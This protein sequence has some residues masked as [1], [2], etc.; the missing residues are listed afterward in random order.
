MSPLVIQKSEAEIS[1][2][3]SYLRELLACCETPASVIEADWLREL[4]HTSASQVS[5]SR[6]PGKRDEEWRF[7]DLSALIQQPFQTAQATQIT[8]EA[9]QPF[10]LPETT[11]SRLVFVNGVYNPELSDVSS[12]PAGVYVGNLSN[13][14]AEYHE[15]L[16]QYLAQQEG[17]SEVFTALNT[18]GMADVA[19]IWAMPNTVVETPIQLLFLAVVADSAAFSQPRILVVAE[20]GSSLHFVEYYGAIAKKC[21]DI[22]ENHPYFTN[23]VTEIW[24]ADNAQVNHSRIQRESGDGFHIGKSAIA[25]AR[26]SRYTCTEVNLGGRLSRHNLNILQAG[27]QTETHL[28]GLTLIGG[29]QVADT[30]SLVS[31][32]K[33]YGIVNQLHKCIVDGSA[34]AIF[35]GKI[36]VPKA[37]QL[38]NAA[39]LNQNLLLS[40]K[41][42][43]NT[44][45]ELQIT[46]DNVKCSHGATVSQL[47][48]DE[49][50][51]LRSRGLTELDARHLL[52]DAF[53][54]EILE[55][56]PLAS[57]RQ[58][59]SQ[60]V[61]CRT[62]D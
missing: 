42:R 61:A 2:A 39:Q 11:H 7:T 43:V 34:H 50:F 55:R 58:R 56:L 13:L 1:L 33:P 52:I 35:N 28:N 9:A 22:P 19:M 37:A 59:L 36:F 20:T 12:L 44:K 15:K 53:A 25:Q 27:E 57:L 49:V 46:A 47:E 26:H 14:R 16:P 60:C 40:A 23:S 21:S 24:L 32:S 30:H 31:L 18:A 51:Y 8:P 29:E 62:V 48:A 38:T 5:Q 6:L 17:T 10:F 54:A 3:D 41:A 4:R 45:P